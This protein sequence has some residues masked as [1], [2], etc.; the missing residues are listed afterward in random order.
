MKTILLDAYLAKKSLYRSPDMDNVDSTLVQ[1]PMGRGDEA[2][3][4]RRLHY[5][6]HIVHTYTPAS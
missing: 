2:G 3:L 5:E 4:E 6:P 1:A